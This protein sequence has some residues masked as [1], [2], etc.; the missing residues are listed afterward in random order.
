[1]MKNHNKYNVVN[2]HF[3]EQCNYH[4]EYCFAKWSGKSMLTLAKQKQVI[5]SIDT[6]F[7]SQGIT[8]G[9]ITLVGGEP[10]VYTHICE[11]IEYVYSK[12]IKVAIETNGSLLT[13]DFVRKYA[14]KIYQIGI[15]VDSLSH[16]V[17][18]QIGR[19]C[20]R[21][22]LSY[23]ELLRICDSIKSAGIHLKINTVVSKANIDE[24]FNKFYQVS[25]A[26][27]I[28][29]LQV[30]F[31]EEVNTKSAVDYAI[32]EK[33]FQ[34]FCARLN[35]DLPT[36]IESDQDIRNSYV[37]INPCGDLFVNDN[38]KYVEVGDVLAEDL[39]SIVER[40]AISQEKFDQRYEVREW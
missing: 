35:P 1:M 8:D 3:I 2:Y 5:D 10:L 14:D 4:C 19:I 11:L 16:S 36:T 6:Y 15:S 7:E 27:K 37:M 30:S 29:I 20:N 22:T 12:G 18:K 28:K 21:K 31:V 33:E 38:G 40:S 39:A 17:N 24:D 25:K 13:N 34:G 9:R 23:D 32:S 26:D